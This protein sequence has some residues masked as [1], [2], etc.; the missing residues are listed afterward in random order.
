MH[1]GLGGFVQD[2]LANQSGQLRTAAVRPSEDEKVVTQRCRHFT[3]IRDDH[4]AMSSQQRGEHQP[5]IRSEFF[6]EDMLPRL[7]NQVVQEPQR[8]RVNDRRQGNVVE[9]DNVTQRV[10][11]QLPRDKDLFPACYLRDD[12][13]GEPR[14]DKH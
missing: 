1:Q 11:R 7:H 6:R 3:R 8:L 5:F 13:T 14:T 4:L 10:E 2:A 12:T 9:G